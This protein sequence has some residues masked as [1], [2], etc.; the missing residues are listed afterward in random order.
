[1]AEII[2]TQNEDNRELSSLSIW[3]K[4]SSLS[5]SIKISAISIILIL[6][7][8]PIIFSSKFTTESNQHAQTIA[9]NQNSPSVDEGSVDTDTEQEDYPELDDNAASS[10]LSN[11]NTSTS[12][13]TIFPCAGGRT[14]VKEGR[15]KDTGEVNLTP[16]PVSVENY[17]NDNKKVPT[18]TKD[19]TRQAP[20]EKQ[21]WEVSGT[22]ACD[23]SKHPGDCVNHVNGE[24]TG[25]KKDDNGDIVDKDGNII[26]YKNGQENK[27]KH[28]DPVYL[29]TDGDMTFEVVSNAGDVYDIHSELPSDVCETEQQGTSPVSPWRTMIQAARA[30]LVTTLVNYGCDPNKRTPVSRI[31]D[32]KTYTWGVSDKCTARFPVTVSGLGFWDLVA[33]AGDDQ[34]ELH[35]VLGVIPPLPTPTSPVPTPTPIP[36]STPVPT[37]TTAPTSTPIP[38]PTPVGST[39]VHLFSS[40]QFISS[41]GGVGSK[42]NNNPIHQKQDVVLYLYNLNTDPTQ[43]LTGAKA[44]ADCSGSFSNACHHVFSSALAYDNTLGIYTTDKAGTTPIVLPGTIPSGQYQLLFKVA[45]YLRKSAGLITISS[46]STSLQ[47]GSTSQPISLE[48]GDINGDNTINLTDYNILKDC[49]SSNKSLSSCP[50]TANLND[51]NLQTGEDLGTFWSIELSLL[52][53][54]FEQINGD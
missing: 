43:D 3:N 49:I 10:S 5:L 54:N 37:P 28:G 30:E 47:I 15:D 25:L 42:L 11:S 14:Q 52:L 1:M 31:I 34:P 13:D 21:L 27:G 36:T 51:A 24:K 9:K 35:P 6:I 17:I 7:V 32:G 50:S 45:G 44:T 38:T 22:V 18:I 12:S 19:N 2:S 29:S 16:T 26:I 40:F 8:I 46:S 53:Q 4:I 41:L 23:I 39:L 20:I 48:A 33:H